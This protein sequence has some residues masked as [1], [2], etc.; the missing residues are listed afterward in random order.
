MIF[1]DTGFLLALFSK[2]DLSHKRARQVIEGY[3]DRPL[4]DLVLTTNHVV[5]ETITLV[6]ARSHRDPKVRHRIAVEVGRQL[7][8]GHFGRIHQASD[9]EEQSAFALVEQH[10]DKNYSFVDCLSFA[11]MKKLGIT[12]AWGV[13]SD[14]I[15]HGFI[16]RP[17]PPPR[18][19]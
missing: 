1:L 6:R 9:E 15:H 12:E 2:E 10:A 7:F 14:F 5:A 17:G 13:D 19:R 18:P 11:I 3:Q 16:V 8:A 4:A